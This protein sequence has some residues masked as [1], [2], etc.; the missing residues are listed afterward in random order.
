M[1]T[2]P[3]SAEGRSIDRTVKRDFF[4]LERK[5]K[6]YVNNG[7][8]A[9]TI[10][11]QDEP[12]VNTK[13]NVTLIKP[14]KK[15]ATSLEVSWLLTARQGRLS[16]QTTGE[17]TSCILH[18]I[19]EGRNVNWGYGERI[20]T[21]VGNAHVHR[22]YLQ[23]FRIEMESQTALTLLSG[24]ALLISEPKIRFAVSIKVTHYPEYLERS[25]RP[26]YDVPET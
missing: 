17:Y 2:T 21:A 7:R 5:L 3:L 14:L 22:S 6:T 23:D 11:T 16:G 19:V 26:D 4:D 10:E 8:I 24:E 9:G 20:C 18:A 15:Q 25:R 12:P 1:E 13:A